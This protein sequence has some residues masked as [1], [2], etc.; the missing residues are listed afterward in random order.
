[1]KENYSIRLIIS[2]RRFRRKYFPLSTC[3]NRHFIFP[4]KEVASA[5]R[6][7][8]G[9][10]CICAAKD[11][12]ILPMSHGLTLIPSGMARDAFMLFIN[13][14]TLVIYPEMSPH[15]RKTK[16]QTSAISHSISMIRLHFDSFNQAVTLGIM[17]H[18]INFTHKLF[19]RF[20][21]FFLTIT[22]I[23]LNLVLKSVIFNKKLMSLIF[24]PGTLSY[25][26]I[27]YLTF[28]YP[29]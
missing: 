4:P 14:Q 7:K 19:S 22:Q 16:R 29:I 1:M 9:R 3:N 10:V 5:I 28:H 8:Q 26:P 6:N 27:Y 15:G 20:Y 13:F 23:L 11:A 24:T 18:K 21:Y 2:K 17:F 25:R 12:L